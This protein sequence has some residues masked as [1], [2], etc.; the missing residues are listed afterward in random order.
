MCQDVKDDVQYVA[1]P[2][3]A[4]INGTIVMVNY[5]TDCYHLQ[6]EEI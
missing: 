3:E 2:Y 4:D 1:D 6:C 5:C